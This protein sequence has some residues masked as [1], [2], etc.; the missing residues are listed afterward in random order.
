MYQTVLK[1]LIY[2]LGIIPLAAAGIIIVN[3]IT[4]LGLIRKL[5]WISRPV[6]RYG[7]LSDASGLS[8]I[9]AFASPTTAN[10]M[11]MNLFSNGVIEKKEL[12]ISVLSNSFPSVLL[13][14]RFILPIIIPLLG[15][16]GLFYYLILLIVAMLKT[17]CVLTVGRIILEK[18]QYI[19]SISDEPSERPALCVLIKTSISDA[20]PLIKKIILLTV[21]ITIITFIS[22]EFGIFKSLEAYLIGITD[23][24]PISPEG[25]SVVAARFAHGVAAYTIAG[26]LLSQGLLKSKEIILSL[27]IANA[28]AGI[29][30]SIRMSTPSYLGIF[31]AGLGTNL[32]LLSLLLRIP[33]VIG[34]IFLIYYLC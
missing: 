33:I 26:N 13:D 31:G 34:F 19:S 10:A 7:H 12:Y 30:T 5:S 1:A 8:F 28:L 32:M 6:V 15:S 4:K 25:I 29:I 24:F 23:I 2:I 17:L 9:T 16:T 22:I 20:I 11:L 27:L 21:P 18:R 14:A 3:I